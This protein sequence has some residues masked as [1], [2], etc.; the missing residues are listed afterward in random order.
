LAIVV[1]EKGAEADFLI[2]GRYICD[3]RSTKKIRP[4]PAK[5]KVAPERQSAIPRVAPRYELDDG[6]LTD[7]QMDEIRRLQPQSPFKG[8]KRLF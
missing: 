4:K 5:R 1:S 3:M 8:T 7:E 6:P 2:S